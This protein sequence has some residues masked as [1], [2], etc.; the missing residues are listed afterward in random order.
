MGYSTA[1]TAHLLVHWMDSHADRHSVPPFNIIQGKSL[2]VFSD[3]KRKGNPGSP[4]FDL[5]ASQR[6]YGRYRKHADLHSI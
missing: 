4:D 2:L 3:F 1:V 5:K 6:W